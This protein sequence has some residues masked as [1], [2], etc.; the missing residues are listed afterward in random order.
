VTTTYQSTIDIAEPVREVE[1]AAEIFARGKGGEVPPQ[2]ISNL[3][4]AV[5]LIMVIVPDST[6]YQAERA[7]LDEFFIRTEAKLERVPD[8]AGILRDARQRLAQEFPAMN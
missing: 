2:A 8:A 3:H 4:L 5:A 7:V 6:R 1:R